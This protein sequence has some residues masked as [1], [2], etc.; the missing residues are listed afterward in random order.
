MPTGPIKTP[1]RNGS[2]QP[3][4]CKS[5]GL[6]SEV[7]SAPKPAPS[8]PLTPWLA[9]C[10]LATKPRRSGMCST[11]NAVEEPNSPPAE[12]PCTSRAS[13]TAIGARMPM[14]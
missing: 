6:I 3:Q 14:V 13:S 5:S 9:N 10:Q 2:R 11:R 8:R 1:N 4:D 12:K 7:R